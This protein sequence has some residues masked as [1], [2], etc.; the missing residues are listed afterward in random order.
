MATRTYVK[1]IVS[2]REPIYTWMRRREVENIKKHI[3]WATLG[4]PIR[5]WDLHP[6]HLR[7]GTAPTLVRNFARFRDF[8]LLYKGG[9]SSHSEVLEGS[10]N[11]HPQISRTSAIFGRAIRGIGTEPM[12][13]ANA[14]CG[15]G[16]RSPE[17]FTMARRNEGRNRSSAPQ[18]RTSRRVSLAR[19]LLWQSFARP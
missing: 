13:R 2:E 18:V 4:Q 5:G 15:S 16:Q 7:V 9:C 19:P 1:V 10:R 3:V 12:R 17:A 14:G 8:V 11:S 6:F